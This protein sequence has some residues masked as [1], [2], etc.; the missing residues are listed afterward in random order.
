VDVVIIEDMTTG[1]VNDYGFEVFVGILLLLT[2]L[3]K[4]K[5]HEY[6]FGAPHLSV[7]FIRLSI[8]NE[9]F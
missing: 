3:V 2:L 4:A 7:S 5:L 6:K 9:L 1:E 8:G